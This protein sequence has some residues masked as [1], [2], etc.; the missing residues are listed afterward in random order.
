[1]TWEQW[2]NSKYNNKFIISDDRIRDEDN[3]YTGLPGVGYNIVQKSNL[4]EANKM[5]SL[6]LEHGYVY[7]G[8]E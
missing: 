4:I 6:T 5:Y 1:M 7:D 8:L 3:I 2:V